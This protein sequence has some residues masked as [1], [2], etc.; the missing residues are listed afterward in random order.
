MKKRLIVFFTILFVITLQYLNAQTVPNPNIKIYGYLTVWALKMNIGAS[1]YENC[2]YTNIDWDACTDY[3]IFDTKF[4]SSGT[5]DVA[6]IWDGNLAWGANGSNQIFQSKRRFL[7]DYIHSK[8]KGVHLCFFCGGTAWTNLLAS[9]ALRDAMI[10]TIVD[11]VIGSTNR[12]DGVHFDLEPMNS[13]V[14]ASD[15]ANSRKFFSAL[16]DTL[17]KYHQWVDV[18]KKPELTITLLGTSGS[19]FFASLQSYVD[20]YLHMTYNLMGNW[21]AI[22]WYNCPVY[23]TGYTGNP[24]NVQSLDQYTQ[25]WLKAGIPPDKL[26]MGC[27]FNYNIFQGGVV[28][29]GEGCYAPLLTTTTYP[30]WMLLNS[31]GN[32]VSGYSGNEMYYS[33]WNKYLDTA[34]AATVHYDPIRQAAWWGFDSTGN[35][36]DMI[37]IFQ[38]TTCVRNILEYLSNQGIRGAMIWEVCGAYVNN[39]NQIR[40]PG[41]AND[42][43][44]QAAKKT[45]Y[46]LLGLAPPPSPSINA[47]PSY[48]DFDSVSV[49]SSIINSYL[50]SGT[51][52]S[53]SSGNITISAPT[54]YQVS[55]SSITGFGASINVSYVNGTLSATTIYVKFTP[56]GGQVYNGNIIHSGGGAPSQNLT[57][58]GVGVAPTLT[59]NPG[60]RAFG[61]IPINSVSPESSYT[62]S[63]TLLVP[64]NG[65]I[66]INAPAG[67]QVSTTTS[68]NYA[69][70]INISYSGGT[71]SSTVIYIIFSPTVVQSYS[72]NISNSGGGAITQT[73]AVS[74]SGV[75]PT[76][77]VTPSSLSFESV[78]M[79]TISSEQTYRVTGSSLLPAS[80]SLT[81]TAPIGYQVSVTTDSGFSSFLHIAYTNSTLSSKT[82]YVRFLPTDVQSYIGNITNAV[83][84]SISQNVAVIGNGTKQDQFIRLFQ[85]YPNPFNSPTKIPYTVLKKTW[86]KLSIFN[87][88]GQRIATLIDQEKDI[89]HYNVEFDPS[90]VNLGRGLQSGCF[91]YRLEI[92]DATVTKK[93]ILLK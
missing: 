67:F 55:L 36:K 14:V 69:S 18:S 11:S 34:S 25:A 26:V 8:G 19:T 27:P 40:H 65:T 81:I 60:S 10:K 52:L 86:V 43:L 47:F 48:L 4:N 75:L 72:G 61:N 78:L 41:L 66:S 84:T 89:G 79:N 31:S 23:N 39:L 28:T 45:R 6:T 2:L 42:H 33:L 32:L 73:V 71:L 20:A 53:P 22:T 1:N 13:A 80:D 70:S 64:T 56:T 68:A 54:G 62:I 90:R 85:N 50:L 46:N 9:P 15:S 93:L 92:G 83:G 87:V 44:L 58:S 3:I 59:V 38:D 91:F 77:S 30:N 82:I 74:G 5:L 21:E 49:G 29:G 7:N 63:G 12:Y 76:L 24:P 57:V 51:N 35:T 16:H 37:A 17:Q 88:L